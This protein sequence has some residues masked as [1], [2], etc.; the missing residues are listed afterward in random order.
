MRV[1]RDARFALRSLSR[2]PGFSLV[3][4]LT[5]ALGIG[6]STAIFSVV[7]AVILRPLD[8]PEPDRLV[9]ITGELVKLGASDTGVTASEVVDFRARPDLFAGVAGMLP[10][11]ANLTGGREPERLDMMLVSWNYFA[12]LGVPPAVGRTFS[13]ADDV[14]GVANVAVVSHEFWRR[15]MNAD[16]RAVGR[17]LTIDGDPVQVVG[18]MPEGFAHP[19]RTLGSG[20][21]V[22]SP[23]GFRNPGA[24]AGSRSY[25]RLEGALARL[26][27]GVSI[28]QAQSRLDDF[29]VAIAQQ[30]P[31]G[32]PP[33][34]G[35]RPRV[36]PLHDD[37]VS[38]VAAPMMVLLAGVG[39]L[40]LVACVNVAHL[41]MARASARRPEMAVRLALGATR[42]RLASQL[43]TESALL[44]FAGGALGVLVAS[45]GVRGLVALAP[46]RIPRLDAVSL[47]IAAVAVTLGISLVVTAIFTFGPAWQLRRAASAPALRDASLRATD[48]R[49]G[50]ARN[51]LVAAEVAM[52]TVL[53]VGAGLFIRTVAGML[54]VP[55]GFETRH[56]LTARISLPRPNDASLAVYL[57]ADRR[58]A[59]YREAASRV[60]A[61]PGVERAAVSSQIPLGGFNRPLFVEIDAPRSQQ[62]GLRPV[63]HQFQIS[64]GYFETMGV[65][66]V[67]GR[68]FTAVD[69]AGAESVAIISEAAM[70]RFWPE[71]DPVGQRLR[72]GPN[73]PWM[74]I[75]GVA[76][77]VLNRRL[78]EPPQPILY[79]P[80][81]QSSDLAAA[82]VVRTRAS[83]TGLGEAIAAAIA[84]VDPGVPVH[85]VRTMED[86]IEAAVAQRRFLMRML[87][88]F[89]A[90]ATA[91]ALLGIYGVMAYSVARR[92][93]EI[94]IRLA[95]GA[96]R[97]DVAGLVLRRSLALTAAGIAAGL[98]ASLVLARLVQSQ[99]FGVEPFDPLT[100]AAVLA[101]MVL[102]AAAA[103][104]LPA[105]RAARVDPAS[106]LR[107]Q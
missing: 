19:G 102:V 48:G 3:V 75:V 2:A 96:R 107:A 8:Y 84:S 58:A 12:V 43:A 94:G 49:A 60:G 38:G 86:L 7:N 16:P 18:V 79:Q 77:D 4:V 20:V 14:P 71:G 66:I 87:M 6:A 25:R 57:D 30:F 74:T 103:A 42:G 80:I 97:A 67:R 39:L 45:W 21:D 101:L 88:V 69:R 82:L 62:A 31:D 51:L 81:E 26:Q 35:W 15:R 72:L 33:T 83:V 93:R 68:G 105:R 56:L 98:A 50:V 13:E 9:R 47:D 40:L 23:A 11:G 70:R 61:L 55:V 85:A 65:P 44:A 100:M 64:P 36:V 95:I 76:G 37:I 91:L 99:L 92:T 46:G 90:T 22:W 32:Y 54:D 17:T 104:W 28:G 29:A 53:L 10:V 106:V 41:V 52:A 63:M 73:A 34:D 5:L 59:F 1:I 78:T 24:A 89:G 27:P